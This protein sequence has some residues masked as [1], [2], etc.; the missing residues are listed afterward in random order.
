MALPHP[1]LTLVLDIDERLD[2][3]EL[4][5]EIGRCYTHVCLTLVRTH[6]ACEGEPQNIAR[7]LVKMGT[8]SYWNS[9]D[10]GADELW[11]GIVERWIG[12]ELYKVGNNMRIFNRRQR[13]EGREPLDFHWVELDLQNGQIAVL[14][15]CDSTSAVDLEASKMVTML[16]DACNEG[17]LGDGVA[18]VLMPSPASYEQQREAG[19]AAKAQREA[20]E[21][22]RLQEEAERAA[23]EAAAAERIAEEAFLESPAL[24]AHQGDE[25]GEA[26]EEADAVGGGEVVEDLYALDEADFALEYRVWQV[27]YADGSVR[28]F[29]SETGSFAA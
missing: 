23:A 3:E 28:I 25:A 26:P 24:S 11:N 8:R 10:E 17:A 19:L 12:N 1:S 2:S 9:S 22:A 4:R 20:E 15:R 27:E 14:L 16:R 7:F 21:A 5:L 18:R 13:D 6:P 29:D